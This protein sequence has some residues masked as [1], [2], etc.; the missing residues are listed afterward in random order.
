[1]PTP[2]Q[3]VTLTWRKSSR[4]AQ[5][6][7]CVEIAQTDRTH[8]RDSKNIAGGQLALPPGQWCTFLSAVKTN[9]DHR[10]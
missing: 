5:N 3:P 4:S 9:A 6:G 8:I 10:P 7:A 1:M 2:Q